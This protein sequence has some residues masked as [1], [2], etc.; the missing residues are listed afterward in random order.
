[1]ASGKARFK[2]L[3]AQ[4]G[5]QETLQRRAGKKG[6]WGSIGRTLGGLVATTLT[7]GAAAPWL[8]GLAAGAGTIGGGALGAKASGTGKLGE[9][10][11]FFREEGEKL[12]RELG[13]FGSK[14]ITGALT[15]ALTAGI[16]Q[17]LKLGKEA[18]AA[19]A[20]DPKMSEEA[21]KAMKRGKGFDFGESALGRGLD[22]ATDVRHV[23]KIAAAD[24][25]YGG[26]K[27]AHFKNIQ[28]GEGGGSGITIET[29]VVK[30]D[31]SDVPMDWEGDIA[32]IGSRTSAYDVQK[33]QRAGME[34]FLSD[35]KNMKDYG[36]SLYREGSV[37]GDD[38]T[39]NIM[40]DYADK[41]FDVTKERTRAGGYDQSAWDKFKGFVDTSEEVDLREKMKQVES[42]RGNMSADVPRESVEH[43]LGIGTGYDPKWGYRPSTWKPEEGSWLRD[44][45]DKKY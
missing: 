35:P 41:G 37:L 1:M 24:K 18:A 21:V 42:L 32:D 29:P 22:K 33:A 30:G 31:F 8:V 26:D 25:L 17:K 9:G 40:S 36:E 10:S 43:K 11:R 44:F 45:Y 34:Q 20:A 19:K 7:G 27:S 14:N 16:G 6:L 28:L 39:R 2:L 13:A 12:Q 23:R 3:R 4:R 15:S 5:E 38:M